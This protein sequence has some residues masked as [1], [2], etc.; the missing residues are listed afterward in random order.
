MREF[1]K[2]FTQITLSVVKK[3]RTSVYTRHTLE[4]IVYLF[5]SILTFENLKEQERLELV[6]QKEINGELSDN[7]DDS[8]GSES[9]DELA[10]ALDPDKTIIDQKYLSPISTVDIL[11]KNHFAKYVMV[12]DVNVR[13]NSIW[14]IKN[15]LAVFDEIDEDT[16]NEL[17][18]VR[19]CL[20]NYYGLTFISLSLS[21]DA[22]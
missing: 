21:P 20:L 5:K 11:I 13:Y 12:K 15:T 2:L 3:E 22:L 9:S 6:T 14:L 19:R 18:T 16:F 1:I 8:M 17:R 4:F 7:M 10:Q